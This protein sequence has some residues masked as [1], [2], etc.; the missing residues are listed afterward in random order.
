MDDDNGDESSKRRKERP[1]PALVH[2]PPVQF[3]NADGIRKAHYSQPIIIGAKSTK[4]EDQ[5]KPYVEAMNTLTEEERD[6]ILC[7]YYCD[8]KNVKQIAQAVQRPSNT[9]QLLLDLCEL[10]VT[11]AEQRNRVLEQFSCSVPLPRAKTAVGMAISH[12]MIGLG[13]AV[14][15]MSHFNTQMTLEEKAR[16]KQELCRERAKYFRRSRERIIYSGEEINAPHLRE[17]LKRLSIAPKTFYA[18]GKTYVWRQ[19]AMQ[20]PVNY[21]D[22]KHEYYH[23]VIKPQLQERLEYN[24]ALRSLPTWLF[25]KPAVPFMWGEGQTKRDKPK[26]LKADGNCDY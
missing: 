17:E 21:L 9:C 25:T 11:S 18:N 24:L 5:L 16:W 4:Q 6:F 12:T 1:S 10:P 23:R 14:G 8:K 22:R 2:G 7:A 20:V 15:A 19:M 26:R 3:F 13:G